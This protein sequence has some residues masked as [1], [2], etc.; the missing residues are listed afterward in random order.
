[1]SYHAVVCA[2]IREGNSVAIWGAGSIG[3][4]AAKWSF[5]AGARRV[6]VIDSVKEYLKIA[7]AMGCNAINFEEDLD[8]LSAIY[9]LEPEGV[10]CAIDT[11]TRSTKGL[12]HTIQRSIGF[13][14]G[15]SGNVNEALGAVKQLGTVSLVADYATLTNRFLLGA[16]MEKGITLR[17]TDQT[18][19]QKYWNDLMRK[20]ENGEFDPAIILSH[21]FQLDELRELYDALDKGEIS[22]LKTFIQTRFSHSPAPGTP[23]L[24]SLKSGTL[25]PSIAA[26][27]NGV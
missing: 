22:V 15:S 10:D 5:L 23:Q 18:P 6:I 16:L 21:R 3:L 20:V 14:I 7:E 24:S 8:V 26:Y 13:E 1:M 11:A 9:K 2:D 25:K 17:G 12:L 27:H 4:Y 19:V